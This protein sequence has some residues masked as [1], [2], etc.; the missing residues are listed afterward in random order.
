LT[1][2]FTDAAKRALLGLATPENFLG[3]FLI[4]IVFL[5]CGLTPMQTD[6]WWQL[7]AGQDMWTSRRILLTDTYSH[8]AYG[9]F[10][11]NHEWLAE[12]IFYG[13]YRAGGLPL[14]TLFAAGLITAAW[15][16]T[17]RL[18]Q[19]PADIVFAVT[20][21]AI[22]P[23]AQWWE[24]RPHAFSLLFLMVTVSL[25]VYQRY[26]WLPLVFLVWANC[27]GGVLLGLVVLC[28]GLGT[29]TILDGRGWKR[30]MLV[31]AGCAMAA[32]VTPLGFAFW[33]EIPRSLYRISLY[34]FDEWK[35]PRL[36]E[37]ALAPFW[38][39]SLVFCAGLLWRGRRLL[40]LHKRD[41]TLCACALV[42]LPASL[43][44]VRNVGP[45]LMVAIPATAS[46]LPIG[47]QSGTT[48]RTSKPLANLA[49]MCLA[50]AGAAWTL[51]WAYTNEIG[52]LR[53]TPLPK[54]ALMALT[55]CPDNLYNRYDE[56]GYLIWFAPD[57]KVFLDGRQDPFPA[58]L[59][60]KHIE[61][62]TRGGPYKQVFA[63][64]GIHCAFLPRTSPTAMQLAADRWKE[65]YRDSRWVVLR[66]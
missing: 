53:W 65:L 59:V 9:S 62:E 57:R 44:A 17:W 39:I 16:I 66:D 51:R 34:T 45:F 12:V 11:P 33:T 25:L 5:V 56:G 7:R 20:A 6:T 27:H 31:I 60:L 32:T 8:T 24:P 19:G 13:M 50:V 22:V 15:V 23:A 58:E 21:L 1:H 3:V 61:M 35:R 38:G 42:L 64:H 48:N 29:Q 46:L 43:R 49:L 2:G 52:R 40:L 26:L 18:T 37:L 4:L 28:A 30:S 14:L 63:Q 36:S 10:W 54:P 55:Q 47:R 41:I